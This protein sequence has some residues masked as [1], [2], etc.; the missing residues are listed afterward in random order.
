MRKKNEYYPYYEKLMEMSLEDPAEETAEYK[1]LAE[2]YPHLAES[3]RLRREKR[4]LK[5]RLRSAA[6]GSTRFQIKREIF[7]I[8]RKLVQESTQKRLHGETMQ[9]A[10]FKAFSIMATSRRSISSFAGSARNAMAK[11]YRGFRSV[12][13]ALR[14]L[15]LRK[16]PPTVFDLRSLDTAEKGL[17][18]REWFQERQRKRLCRRT[19]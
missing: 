5:E 18:V 6:N 16:L 3:I 12:C 13:R 15:V 2:R 7:R 1:I 19:L 9:E 8:E 11:P 14:R 17:A 4:R 10:I